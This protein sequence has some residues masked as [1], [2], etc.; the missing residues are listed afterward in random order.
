MNH[1]TRPRNGDHRDIMV[2]A[3]EV[4]IQGEVVYVIHPPR[5]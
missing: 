2:P 3:D 1:Q 4:V 5:M